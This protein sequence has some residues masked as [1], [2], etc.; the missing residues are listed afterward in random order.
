VTPTLAKGRTSRHPSWL[1]LGCG[2]CGNLPL[3]A[4][5]P[6]PK[7]L[8]INRLSKNGRTFKQRVAG[9]N[10]AGRAIFFNNLGGSKR[11]AFPHVHTNVHIAAVLSLRYQ[12]LTS[13]L[14]LDSNLCAPQCRATPKSSGGVRH[15]KAH[16]D[17]GIGAGMQGIGYPREGGV[18]LSPMAST[19][20]RKHVCLF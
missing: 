10:P 2:G 11:P 4:A 19:L 14:E 15:W 7:S 5:L 12:S 13:A 6:R 9:S 8:K 20:K 18:E 1:R 17:S 3:C 16:Q